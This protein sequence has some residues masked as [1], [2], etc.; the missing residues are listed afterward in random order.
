MPWYKSGTVSVT[1]NSNAV[2]GSGTAFI[3]NSRVG[4]GFRGPDG[5]WYEVTNIASDTAMSISPNYQGASNSAGGYALAPLQGYV[6]ESADRLRALVLQYGDK[7]AALG[8]T[9][10]YDVLPV[11]KGGTGRTDGR[12]LLT[13]VGVQQAA[14][15]YNSQGMYMGWNSGSQGEGHFIVNQG[16]G[17]G[18]FTWR[19]V[20][21]NNSSGG[22]V[23]S[24][25]YG[26]L[27]SVPQLALSTAL[28]IANG[29]TGA[30]NKDDALAAIDAQKKRPSLTALS[31]DTF[32]AN[33][34]PFFT[35]SSSSS[36]MTVTPYARTLLDDAD[37]AT[38]CATLGLG[39]NSY[40]PRFLFSKGA[41]SPNSAIATGS[42]LYFGW[43]E[44]AASG[45]ANFV[46]NRGLGIGGFSWRTIA[47]DNSATGPTMTLSYGAVLN[48]P[49]G[50]TQSSDRNLKINDVEIMDGLER[51]RQ[52]R[53]VEYD[54]KY[55]LKDTTY[56]LHEAGMIAQ[57]LYEVL[58][59]V[60]TPAGKGLGQET[61]AV[62]YTSIIP[63][64]VSAIKELA[65]SNDELS[66]K[67][68][69]LMAA[70]NDA[71]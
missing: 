58:P 22:P 59:L 2:I 39:N 7:L 5:G 67:V 26:G 20:N 44:S 33:Q 57:E 64:L 25:S 10:N 19:S 23:M 51:V 1:Q 70:R 24:Y 38:A 63:Y 54:R 40:A 4:D 50:V 8:T 49:G 35:G 68:E 17:A 6:K 66:R 47:N 15:L 14:V 12:V 62:N 36:L 13:E 46:C 16:G 21:A 31:F 69:E 65:S 30:N 29:G 18:G 43:N 34:V 52:I 45:E 32:A 56:P 28:S 11:A 55:N 60:V 53:P 27:L 3:A 9:G 48:V 61:W 41:S 37:A 42:G 71:V